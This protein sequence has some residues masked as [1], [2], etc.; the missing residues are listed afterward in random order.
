MKRKNDPPDKP[1]SKPP[2]GWV[3]L[4][5]D[6]SFKTEDGTAGTG[7]ILRDAD[8]GIIFSA[9]R[10]LQSCTEALEAELSSC[11]EGLNLAIQHSQLP[12]IIDSDCSQLVASAGTK[13]Q[14]RSAFL[15][16]ISEIKFIAGSD[17]VCNFVKVDRGQVRVSHCLANWARTE[18]ITAF[19]LGSAPD[20]I[21]EL[22]AVPLVTPDA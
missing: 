4:T 5:I 11:L 9:C 10:S 6:G 20:I 7:M 21:Q 16:I 2:R 22:I 8:G 19:W 3:K 13:A 14:D 1:W 15:H 12:I 18:N 17:R